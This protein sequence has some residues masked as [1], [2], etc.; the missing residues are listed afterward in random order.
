MREYVHASSRIKEADIEQRGG[1]CI[2]HRW[3]SEGE[4]SA[5][6]V[7]DRQRQIHRLPIIIYLC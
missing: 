1:A 2:A 7:A 4:E 6:A 5:A 3:Q